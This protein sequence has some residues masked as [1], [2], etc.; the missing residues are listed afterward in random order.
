MRNPYEVLE[1]REGATKEEIKAAYKRQVK[2][3]HPDRHQDNPLY[4]LA[5][6]KLQ[7]I[8]D[9]Y[10]YLM[11]N[12]SYDGGNAYN[13]TYNTPNAEFQEIR[14]NIDRGNIGAAEA[15][16]NRSR[17]RGAEW[18]FLNGMV[19]L[20]KGWYDNAVTSMQTAVSMDPGNPEYRNAMNNLLQTSG[21]YRTTA[22]G[23]GFNN[24]EL[25]RMMQCYCCA[26]ALC[27]CI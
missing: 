23:R 3:Y 8:N 18:H 6:Q 27:D 2:K 5:Q 9:A 20:R 7:E 26:D 24:D 11:K 19:S 17:N 12:G 1:I 13:N 16:L 15:A 25:C 14:R 22:Y 21:G 4:E 10:D